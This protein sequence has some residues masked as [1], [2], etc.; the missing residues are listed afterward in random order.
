M[1]L[2][3]CGAAIAVMLVVAGCGSGSPT[4]GSNEQ[5][6][7]TGTTTQQT[8]MH[9]INRASQPRSPGPHP[10]ARVDQLIVRDVRVGTGPEIHAG[11]RG[12]FEFI[13]TNWVTG[14]P[15]EAAWHKRRPFET[16]IE[17]G[18]VIDGWWQG[19]P[20]MRV[21]GRRRILIPPSLGFTTNPE[22]QSATTYFDVVLV[23]VTR[24]QPRGVGGGGGQTAG[25]TG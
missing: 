18:V 24:Q 21:G 14:K 17:H 10:G 12:I 7:T 3:L 25:A 20:G 6:A 2:T 5:A 8:I 1:R 19:I 13:A 4:S 11:D 16:Q 23:Q 15:I 9:Y 22:L